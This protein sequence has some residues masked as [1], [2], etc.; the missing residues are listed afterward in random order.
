MLEE[1]KG[2]YNTI[3]RNQRRSHLHRAVGT[4]PVGSDIEQ[5]GVFPFL[6]HA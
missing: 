5:G 4:S 2:K 3:D 6:M 1:G